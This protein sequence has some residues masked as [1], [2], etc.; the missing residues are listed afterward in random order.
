MS[1]SPKDT[2]FSSI[3][4]LFIWEKWNR[5]H[6]RGR[7]RE[8][9]THHLLSREPHPSLDSR[10]QTAW[11]EVKADSSMT[12]HYQYPYLSYFDVLTDSLCPSRFTPGYVHNEKV[13]KKYQWGRTNIV[14]VSLSIINWGVNVALLVSFHTN[15]DENHTVAIWGEIHNLPVGKSSS[16][17]PLPTITLFES[18]FAIGDTKP[19]NKQGDVVHSLSNGFSCL[20]EGSC[21]YHLNKLER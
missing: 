9:E 12:E 5:S 16:P 14:K 18:I 3:F 10:S 19:G 20:V 11:L 17:C 8:R 2:L 6:E 13:H 7:S 4:Y 15:S 1:N 21:S